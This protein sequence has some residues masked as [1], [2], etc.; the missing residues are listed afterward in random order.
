MKFFSFISST[1]S[2]FALQILD[3][4]W[5]CCLIFLLTFWQQPF[6]PRRTVTPEAFSFLDSDSVFVS[7]HSEPDVFG[8]RYNRHVRHP[9][10]DGLAEV[11]PSFKSCHLLWLNLTE[12]SNGGCIGGNFRIFLPIKLFLKPTSFSGYSFSYGRVRI[13]FQ[14]ITRVLNSL[15]INRPYSVAADNDAPK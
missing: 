12:N 11:C 5:L 9:S 1:L 7:T 2:Y 6:F 3:L 8:A 15:C 14:I 10:P 13:T 4:C